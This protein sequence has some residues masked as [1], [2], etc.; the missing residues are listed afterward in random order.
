[1]GIG[2]Q[3]KLTQFLSIFECVLLIALLCLLSVLQLFYQ[4]LLDSTVVFQDIGLLMIIC[5]LLLNWRFGRRPGHYVLLSMSA[6]YLAISSMRQLLVYVLPVDGFW[7]VLSQPYTWILL[8]SIVMAVIFIG[9]VLLESYLKPYYHPWRA[10]GLKSLKLS[11]L[12]SGLALLFVS[13]HMGAAVISCGPVACQ[14]K[15]TTY[16]GSVLFSKE[17][18]VEFDRLTG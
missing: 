14:Q 10:H 4:H 8:L 17:A 15:A 9:H 16:Q 1:M 5:G 13:T 18:R 2:F 11:H 7:L 12:F 6:I 3:K